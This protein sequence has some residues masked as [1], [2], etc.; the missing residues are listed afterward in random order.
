MDRSHPGILD[1]LR[2]LFNEDKDFYDIRYTIQPR[3]IE[4]AIHEAWAR[5]SQLLET[6]GTV[7]QYAMN[8]NL[9]YLNS[10][11]SYNLNWFGIHGG[12]SKMIEFVAAEP[13]ATIEQMNQ[14]LYI[15]LTVREFLISNV[16]KGIVKEIHAAVIHSMLNMTD[17]ELRISQKQDIK[18]M[19]SY[20]E[21]LLEKTYDETSVGEILENFELGLA[22][23]CLVSP[24][25]EKRINGLSEIITKI[26]QARM[27]YINEQKYASSYI[28]KSS[29]ECSKWLTSSYLLE[30]VD[31]KDILGVIFGSSSHPELIKRSHELIRFLYTN[32]RFSR[33][34]IDLI[35]ANAASKHEAERDVIMKLFQSLASSLTPQDIQ[36]FFS[37]IISMPY[38]EIDSEMLNLVKSFAR[39]LSNV[40]VNA[41]PVKNE[42]RSEV[43]R[44]S[45]RDTEMLGPWQRD[46]NI[47][48]INIPTL[49]PDNETMEEI[50]LLS[51]EEKLADQNI[52][53]EPAPEFSVTRSNTFEES[54]K[55]KEEDADSTAAEEIGE[56]NSEFEVSQPLEFLWALCQEEALE[57]GLQRSISVQAQ[58]ILQDLL[59]VYF[60]N[61]R[62][63]Y[64][65]RCIDCIRKNTSVLSA[66]QLLQKILA[67]HHT[68]RLAPS[69]L[70]N[71]AHMIKWLEREHHLISELFNSFLLF[72]REAV[73]QA[74]NLMIVD[75][76]KPEDDTRVETYSTCS[77]GDE[78]KEEEKRKQKYENIFRKVVVS[79]DYEVSYV[80]EIRMRLDFLTYLFANSTE[81]LHPRHAHILWEALVLNAATESEQN[82]GF[83]WL[84]KIVSNGHGDYN[85]IDD[86]VAHEVYTEMLLKL[87]ARYVTK[88]AMECLEKYFI[89]INK[90]H[91]LLNKYEFDDEI[92]VKD[93]NLLGLEAIWEIIFQAR[94]AQ[95]ADQANL[96]LKRIYKGLRKCDLEVQE[97]LLRHCMNNITQSA[98]SD[99]VEL[100]SVN[101]ITRSLNILTNFIQEFE[102]PGKEEVQGVELDIHVNNTTT[103]ALSPKNFTI[104]LNSGMK[105]SEAKQQIAS[106]LNPSRFPSELDLI[107]RGKILDFKADNKLLAELG[108]ED[109]QHVYVTDRKPDFENT[110][111]PEA[112]PEPIENAEKTEKISSLKLIFEDVED[113]VIAFAL[114][115]CSWACDE[116][117]E[118][119]MDDFSRQNLQ[120]Q[121][122]E[123]A[124]SK[125][126]PKVE[127]TK[128]SHILSNT[129]EYFSLL[130]ELLELGNATINERVWKLLN[131]IPVNQEMYENIRTLRIIEGYNEPQ[132]DSLL[133]PSC[134]YKLL[135]SLQI[136]NSFISPSDHTASTQELEERQ[137]WRKRFLDLGGFKHLYN[138]LL[139]TSHIHLLAG[140]QQ[141]NNAKCLGFLLNVVKL[142]IQAALLTEPCE[143]LRMIFSPQASPG[144]KNAGFFCSPSKNEKELEAAQFNE[145]EFPLLVREMSY[146]AANRVLDET[147]FCAL[148]DKLLDIVSDTLKIHKEGET[149]KVIES[150]MDLLV[151]ILISKPELLSNLYEREDLEEIIIDSLLY[152]D[153]PTR[154]AFKMAI[155]TLSDTVHKTPALSPSPARFFLEKLLTKIPIEYGTSST[156]YFEL[157]DKLIS[158]CEYKDTNLLNFVL[159]IIKEREIIEDRHINN[160]DEVLGGMLLIV[161]RLLDLMTEEKSTRNEWV[162]LLYDYL[163]QIP[164]LGQFNTEAN[165]LPKIKHKET[166]KKAFGLLLVLCKDEAINAEELLS[167]LYSNH[168]DTKLTASL[169][170]DFSAKSSVGYVGLHNFGSTCYMNS[171]MQQFFMMR[172][173]RKKMLEADI[174]IPLDG[175][176]SIS[177][178]IV[179][180]FQH[181]L[182]YLQESEKE[183]YSP[184]GFIQAFKD[185]EGMP[186]N[187][188][189]QQDVDEFFN[190]FCD[191]LENSLKLTK[192][193]KLLRNFLGGT[194]IH[195]IVSS[196]SEYPYLGEREEEFFRISLDIKNK[197]NLADALDLFIKE[198]LLEGDNKYYCDLYE[199][200]INVKKR[201]LIHTLANT[202]IIHLKRFEFDFSSMQRYKINDYCEFPMNINFKPWTKEGI[203]GGNE[204]PDE[205]FE[206]ELVGV[207]V[208]SGT[209]D[210]G[211][212]YS[213]IKDRQ[214]GKWYCFDDKRV[215][216]FDPAHLAE[217]CFGGNATFSIGSYNSGTFAK[218]RNAYMCV[219]ERTKPLDIEICETPEEIA[220]R[221]KA[222]SSYEIVNKT[223]E[224]MHKIWNENMEFI[225]DRMFYDTSYIDFLKSF[226]NS[227]SFEPV[228]TITEEM[229]ESDQLR[230]EKSLT[231]YILEDETRIYKH[232]AIILQDSELIDLLN[233]TK[234]TSARLKQLDDQD[235]TL[236]LIKLCTLFAYEM[237]IRAKNV[238]VFK[239]WVDI[240][241]KLYEKHVPACLWFL[242]YLD[243]NRF[244]M[245]DIL[246]ENKHAEVRYIFSKLITRVL[247]IASDAEQ[248]L[249]YE[250][251]EVYNLNWISHY[252]T[253]SRLTR[254]DVFEH[255]SKAASGRFIEMM[256]DSMLNEARKNWRRFN[257]FFKV[258]KN[259]TE[260][261]C[262]QCK[263][264]VHKNM[265]YK[266]LELYMN[267]SGPFPNDKYQMGD[268]ATEPDMEYIIDT[269]S[270]LVSS[271]ITDA[272]I[273]LQKYAPTSLF[274]SSPHK[275]ELDSYTDQFFR[276]YK[277]YKTLLN[278][279]GLESI[280]RI[281]IHLAWG[282][283]SHSMFYIEELMN[284][285][286]NY[287][288]NWNYTLPYL[289]ILA[290]IFSLDDDYKEIRV[291]KA[292][293][294]QL[295]RGSVS[296]IKC[297]F[298]DMVYRFKDM[299]MMFTL[300]VILWWTDLFE[301]PHVRAWST[302]NMYSLKWMIHYVKFFN[303]RYVPNQLIM[304]YANNMR[305]IQDSAKEALRK[306]ENLI[307]DSSSEEEPRHPEEVI[308]SN[309]MVHSNQNAPVQQDL[310]EEDSTESEGDLDNL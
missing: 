155:S 48:V 235:S 44:N 173:F 259:Y 202:V 228:Y 230:N 141:Q 146:G 135:Y 262:M 225:R 303:F 204:F 24:Y 123:S 13:H 295:I 269:L 107:T 46:N 51:D 150:A 77:S 47:P 75:I 281:T 127:Y 185:F 27:K 84:S 203:T 110:Y 234:E 231:R 239:E 187:P 189:I 108:F 94:E 272:M 43:S 136:V 9:G 55:T 291:A 139:N 255:K 209:A 38:I 264:L 260:M 304:D 237:L 19:M 247:E 121:L 39:S 54:T 113:R 172:E 300:L 78:N 124:K 299:H 99:P 197:K 83:S 144:K 50:P 285:I 66:C 280:Q 10:F 218:V 72:K 98:F 95:V 162:K 103:S 208:H 85:I 143:E 105:L 56:A 183:Y 158:I 80:E 166:R 76:E 7:P 233:S 6:S 193:A 22:F 32:N 60:R 243:Y 117:A 12:F 2:R 147:D 276:D 106:R 102:K 34:N 164:E 148:V 79:K 157:L 133:D 115:K 31:R 307:E 179:Y 195:E 25:L 278:H 191:K 268:Q 308:F 153:E 156:Q 180:Q 65:I 267:N 11:F 214:T 288:T 28:Y 96:L 178:S 283:I 277:V 137:D 279:H 223:S 254:D 8:Q 182:S 258:L 294:L 154:T 310:D 159:N 138:V 4:A 142:F 160:Q 282:S 284:T 232:P 188:R 287:K 17:E 174:K 90:Q 246:L 26:S 263:F 236:K 289:R 145:Q 220:A 130:F 211:H 61:E 40:R 201:C 205:Y 217:E 227:Y 199:L 93:I 71:R 151:P 256:C 175:S 97:A 252:K 35:W 198:D 21:S 165:N 3:E 207:L 186:M 266:L 177:D 170:S 126:P 192:D 59:T 275:P 131:Q 132:W 196:E 104:K 23:K 215:K 212:Y 45:E 18:H 257:D 140:D 216:P 87:D 88:A 109:K 20:L 100:D 286:I 91:G 111:L 296:S 229:S 101:R 118:M 250:F 305:N 293:T 194:F 58:E 222:A 14:V 52:E 67:S 206:Y 297:G 82:E 114:E 240:L 176:E 290:A 129:Y 168:S 253:D 36:Y 63:K 15:I 149:F 167:C 298:W 171:L 68:Y 41:A 62:L 265:I 244:I 245:V 92:D 134:M 271:C 274:I 309:D 190:L 161:T 89:L 128:V 242:K 125:Q 213:Y 302:T 181:I 64:C 30:W 120:K 184:Y 57:S 219:Y 251:E 238:E 261:G 200:K 306:L 210:A 29:G 163:F 224:L 53:S 270:L 70:E 16:W 152:K 49:K 273:K 73:G 5:D 81:T 116:A 119:L 33:D 112:A 226:V 37:K 69:Q 74:L 292:M 249:L 248:N 42:I 241:I 86:E 1:I 122:H 169:D 221:E 301:L